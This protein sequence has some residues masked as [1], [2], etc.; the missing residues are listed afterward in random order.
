MAGVDAGP[1]IPGV[2]MSAP[3]PYPLIVSALRRL[4]MTTPTRK[5]KKAS[6]KIAGT[7]AYLCEQCRRPAQKVEVDHIEPVGSPSG[8]DGWDGFMRRLFCG[9]EGL[10]VLC[11]SKCHK[12]KT[13][14][15]AAARRDGS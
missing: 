1:R 11:K 12:A 5:Q 7:D 8:S 14:A 4:W 2:T 9:P 6:R 3:I 10:R 15:E 13:A